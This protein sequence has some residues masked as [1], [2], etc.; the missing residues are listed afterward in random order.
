M[1][2]RWEYLLGAFSFALTFILPLVYPLYGDPSNMAFAFFPWIYIFLL[3]YSSVFLYSIFQRKNLRRIP[4]LIRTAV[5]LLSFV[6]GLVVLRLLQYDQILASHSIFQPLISPRLGILS[7]FE[8]FFGSVILLGI[9]VNYRQGSS[10]WKKSTLVLSIMV[11][12]FMMITFWLIAWS[13]K[14]LFFDG[15]VFFNFKNTFTFP[16][17]L[18]INILSVVVLILTHYFGSQHLIR[19]MR[20]QQIPAYQRYAGIGFAILLGIGS[21]WALPINIFPTISLVLMALF[22]FLWDF[23]MD[24]RSSNLSWTIFLLFPYSFLP[25]FIF[26]KYLQQFSIEQAVSQVRHL[27]ESRDWQAEQEMG[28]LLL[29]IPE[30][31]ASISDQAWKKIGRGLLQSPHI[32]KNY[33]LKAIDLK[34]DSFELN[35]ISPSASLVQRKDIRLNYISEQSSLVFPYII[36]NKNIAVLLRPTDRYQML[37]PLSDSGSLFFNSI[38]RLDNER[39]EMVQRIKNWHF[40]EQLAR[41]GEVVAYPPNFKSIQ[42]F[43]GSSNG[44]HYMLRKQTSGFI[45]PIAISSLF[46]ILILASLFLVQIFYNLGLI[47][48]GF[49]IFA[50]DY[51]SFSTKIQSG[52]IIILLFSFFSIG[53]VATTFF[54]NTSTENTETLLAHDLSPILEASEMDMPLRETNSTIIVPFLRFLIAAFALFLS[55]AIVLTIVITN[56]I[57]GPISR[58]GEKLSILS[59]EKNQ[60]LEWNSP[61]EIGQLISIYNQMIEKVEEQARQLK[62]SEREE[63][64]RE[65]AQQVAHE[66]KNPL[67]PMK[68]NVQYLLRAKDQ[69]SAEERERLLSRISKTLIE[70]IDSLSRI[71]TEFSNFAKMPKAQLSTFSLNQLL[72]SVYHLFKDQQSDQL[73]LSLELPEEE[74]M[75]HADKEQFLRVL[76]NLVKNGIQAIP[77]ERPGQIGITLT[78]E[79]GIASIRVRD[80]GS[81]IPEELRDKVFVPNFTTKSSGTGLGLAISKNI[82]DS[83]NGQISFETQEGKGTEFRVDVPVKGE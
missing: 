14:I 68:L 20:R 62:K 8:W 63:A 52:T 66:I 12:G 83:V 3:G 16:P 10:I 26:M 82:V 21:I 33:H 49:N 56:T 9:V 57:T 17:Q 45:E 47:K 74:I 58:L 5:L 35:R 81:G 60:P 43:F 11:Y 23:Y 76:N 40:S 13:M 27:S 51:D 59:L 19:Y 54:Q 50:V 48:D 38:Q 73:S 70:Q 34:K 41:E 80:N 31:Q 61:D 78:T 29:S 67:T 44:Q 1:N 53:M 2:K 7:P 72:E 6:A 4:I 71:A 24:T 36:Y 39:S 42:L 64:W 18:I 28:A 69:Q 32:R 77:E 55:M 46:F 25:G 65:M 37:D 22:L 75:V 15:P 30:E 79:N